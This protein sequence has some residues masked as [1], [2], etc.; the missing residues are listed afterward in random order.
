VTNNR[1]SVHHIHSILI[2][3]HPHDLKFT[4]YTNL[5]NKSCVFKHGFE[6]RTKFVSSSNLLNGSCAGTESKSK[7][8][9]GS[10]GA[11]GVDAA[12]WSS[13]SPG[14]HRRVCRAPTWQRLTAGG[15]PMAPVDAR[16][17][18]RERERRG[19]GVRERHENWF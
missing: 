7:G 1:T 3:Q 17:R 5:N 12:R 8:R 2:A 16:E 15:A 10:R 4:V 11:I 6:N 19:C 18:G 13:A 9:P 14:G